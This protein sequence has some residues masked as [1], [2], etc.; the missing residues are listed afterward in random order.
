MKS[1]KLLALLH[2]VGKLYKKSTN[3]GHLHAEVHKFLSFSLF[4]LAAF[5]FVLLR[6]PQLNC[7]QLANLVQYNFLV[8]HFP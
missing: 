4:F 5:A 8:S 2:T 7:S 1:V 6:F 3:D